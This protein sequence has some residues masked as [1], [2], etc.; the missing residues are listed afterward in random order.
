MPEE[1]KWQFELEEYIR[2]GKTQQAQRSEAW[3]TAIGL[4]DVDGLQTSVYLVDTAREHIEGKNEQKGK[5]FTLDKLAILKL[6]ALEL[7]ITQKEIA[8]RIGTTERTVKSKMAKLQDE[9]CIHRINGKRSG[10]WEI[11]IGLL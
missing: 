11:L 4:Q 9:N 8:I 5:K 6:V 2:Q 1:T 3:Q 7:A 10:K